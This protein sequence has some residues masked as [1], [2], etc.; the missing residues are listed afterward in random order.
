MKPVF[1]AYYRFELSNNGPKNW[2]KLSRTYGHY[3]PLKKLVNRF[4][5]IHITYNTHL[6]LFFGK[7][8]QPENEGSILSYMKEELIGI[9]HFSLFNDAII[10]I[11]NTERKIAELFISEDNMGKCLFLYKDLQTGRLDQE[12]ASL[13]KKS[14]AIILKK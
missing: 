2:L 5:K 10:A 1:S 14:Q 3:A 9:A 12:I 8:N 13:R 7:T 6:F 11:V 4:I